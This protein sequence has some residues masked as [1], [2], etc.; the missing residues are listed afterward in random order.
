MKN[1]INKLFRK[2]DDNIDSL[3]PVGEPLLKIEM[4]YCSSNFKTIL[5]TFSDHYNSIAIEFLTAC[6]QSK[7]NVIT[8]N[9]PINIS[10]DDKKSDDFVITPEKIPDKINY[11]IISGKDKDYSEIFN[12][13][14]NL[15]NPFIRILLPYIYD[16]F[17]DSKFYIHIN[18]GILDG[19]KF[20]HIK[21][22]NEDYEFNT[23]LVRKAMNI[24]SVLNK[25]PAVFNTPK[26]I[27]IITLCSSPDNICH[28]F[29]DIIKIIHRQFDY[30]S[31]ET[32]EFANIFKPVF[33]TISIEDMLS[34]VDLPRY[35][36]EDP[37]NDD[38]YV[39][40][41]VGTSHDVA[42]IFI[43][44]PDTFSGISDDNIEYNDIDE[45]ILDNDK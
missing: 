5:Y 30:A 26:D 11:I 10:E 32:E 20:A 37:D 9:E 21:P 38:T 13:I 36:L 42:D 7:I 43:N 41:Y 19:N 39:L 40:N 33:N 23:G 16:Y 24:E 34:I 25:I 2:K 27:A 12:N 17:D 31:F 22:E 3:N 35:A 1:L 28:N 45:V 15:Q 4:I 44:P 18:D 8:E 6:N 14:A 29:I